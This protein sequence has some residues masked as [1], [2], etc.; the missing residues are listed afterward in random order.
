MRKIK[1]LKFPLIFRF[2]AKPVLQTEDY[3]YVSNE[4]NFSMIIYIYYFT[5]EEKNK[6]LFTIYNNRYPGGITIR[7]DI[8]TLNYYWIKE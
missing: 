1:S 7:N 2:F 4:T 8:Y 5:T 3:S 6:I